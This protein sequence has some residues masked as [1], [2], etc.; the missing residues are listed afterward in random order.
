MIPQYESDMTEADV[1]RLAPEVGGRLSARNV[2]WF[3]SDQYLPEQ[4][5]VAY[6]VAML[7]ASQLIAEGEAD[8]IPDWQVMLLGFAPHDDE[9][10]DAY[11]S[12]M[13]KNDVMRALHGATFGDGTYGG[14]VNAEGWQLPKIN[15]DDP[16]RYYFEMAQV[17]T[18]AEGPRSIYDLYERKPGIWEIGTGI[19]EEI[20][21]EGIQGVNTIRGYMG[22]EGEIP[23][24]ERPGPNTNDLLYEAYSRTSPP[25]E[26]QVRQIILNA[27][28]VVLPGLMNIAIAG[29]A[30]KLG[31]G[32]AG[33]VFG[34]AASTGK[35]TSASLAIARN[36]SRVASGTQKGL[37]ARRR[38][39]L[40][41]SALTAAN[42]IPEQVAAYLGDP[43]GAMTSYGLSQ[44][45]ADFLTEVYRPVVPVYEGPQEADEPY[46]PPSQV[47]TITTR[48]QTPQVT[49]PSQRRRGGGR[50]PRQSA[51]PEGTE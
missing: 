50:T 49:P 34:A 13:E 51:I 46:V 17:F 48:M 36:L 29:G 6:V 15:L 16:E 23:P 41:F 25:G 38:F 33:A 40:G 44:D 8:Q 24:Y 47:S 7:A 3:D 10:Q 42:Y 1:D 31:M 22:R 30:F 19:L 45:Q 20:W 11:H 27:A 39:M 43:E 18:A 21:N 12:K 32:A 2:G 14:N 4:R 28:D 9:A 26:D 37:R 35:G 5:Y